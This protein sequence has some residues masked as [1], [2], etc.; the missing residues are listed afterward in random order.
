MGSNKN[1][2]IAIGHG[3]AINTDKNKMSA[4]QAHKKWFVHPLNTGNLTKNNTIVKMRKY[5][6]YLQ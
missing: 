3:I 2:L 4:V 5:F 1:W 6:Y